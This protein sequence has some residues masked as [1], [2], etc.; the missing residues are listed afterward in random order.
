LP[1]FLKRDPKITGK[2]GGAFRLRAIEKIAVV[3]CHQ[4]Q[5]SRGHSAVVVLMS[6]AVSFA[7]AD[8]SSHF[9]DF[10]A[11]GGIIGTSLSALFLFLLASL[12]YIVLLSANG[13]SGPRESNPCV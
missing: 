11:V 3:A 9:E 13:C 1:Y 4:L 12:L 7:T 2:K 6:H 8:I 10:K 5:K